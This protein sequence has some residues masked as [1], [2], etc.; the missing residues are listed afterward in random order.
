MVPAPYRLLQLCRVVSSSP[1]PQR[2]ARSP[3]DRAVRSKESLEAAPDAKR[4]H[5]PATGV[6]VVAV[7]EV[8]VWAP[9]DG[10]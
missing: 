6:L 9:Q 5:R 3:R 2:S 1:R 7:V 4:Q 10:A 8:M